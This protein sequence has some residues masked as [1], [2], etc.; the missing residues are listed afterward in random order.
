MLDKEFWK[1]RKVLI[2][3]HTGFK[4]SWL[5]I[6]LL[7]MGAKVCGYS[8]EK[9]ENDKLY[10]SIG[11]SEEINDIRG[12]I[13]DLEKLNLTFKSFEPEIVFH[14]AAQPLVRQSYKDPVNTFKTNIIGTVNILETLRTSE[15]VK[16]AVI[17]TSDKVYENKEWLYGYRETDRLGG[18]DPYSASKGA[19]EIVVNSYIESFFKESKINIATARAGNVIGGGDY[20]KDRLIPDCISS[21]Q[22]K[23]TIQIRNPSSVRPWQHVLDP[24]H[25]YLLLAQKLYVDDSFTGAWNFAPKRSS[26][27]TVKELVKQFTS[28]WGEGTYNI[29][30]TNDNYKETTFLNLDYTKSKFNLGWSPKLE[31]N[32]ALTL[33]VNWYKNESNGNS[34]NLCLNQIDY[35]TRKIN[36]F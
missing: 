12:D 21:L 17:I 2:T 36:N 25:G 10:N 35:F 26:I 19:T 3:G 32:D 34:Y 22:N 29:T 1:D 6:W 8:L 11:I 4:G 23:K 31:F 13:L 5:T 15:S 33:T 7:S 20:S 18:K 9:Y 24:L 14:M 28:I 16:A 27:V 30:T